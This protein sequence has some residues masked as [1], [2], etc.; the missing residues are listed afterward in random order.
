MSNTLFDGLPLVQE[1]VD[2]VNSSS[3]M[4]NKSQITNAIGEEYSNSAESQYESMKPAL[5]SKIANIRSENSSLGDEYIITQLIKYCRDGIKVSAK[6][7]NELDMNENSSAKAR[8]NIAGK[9][10]FFTKLS[11]SINTVNSKAAVKSFR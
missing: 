8:G 2:Q 5:I 11:S 10:T 9:L 7:R 3:Y 4:H 1:I 6:R